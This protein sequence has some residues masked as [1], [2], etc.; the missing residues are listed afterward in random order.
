M[1]PASV[2]STADEDACRGDSEDEDDDVDVEHED[3]D[4]DVDEDE[5]EALLKSLSFIRLP[6]DLLGPGPPPALSLLGALSCCCCCCRA[7]STAN[8]IAPE[9]KDEGEVVLVRVKGRLSNSGP[10]A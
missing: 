1:L 3:V 5:D 8:A 9:G 6:P 10:L 2:A 4:A 7:A